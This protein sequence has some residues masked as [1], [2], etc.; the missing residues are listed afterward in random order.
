MSKQKPNQKKSTKA[1]VEQRTL[2]VYNMLLTGWNR[3]DIIQYASKNYKIDERATDNYIKKANDKIKT[4]YNDEAKSSILE[5]HIAIKYNLFQ[6]LHD[7]E[8]YKGANSILESI[9]K[10]LNVGSVN[11]TDITSNGQT[12]SSSARILTKQE[13]KELFK[14]LDND[15]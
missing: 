13:A 9:E 10:M 7:E 12:I 1:V 2:E 15:Y 4:L 5:K 6:K 3:Q 11:K 8:D 14:D